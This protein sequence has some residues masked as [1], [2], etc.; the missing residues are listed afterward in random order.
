[1]KN[2]GKSITRSAAF[3]CLFAL[4]VC[5]LGSCSK[6]NKF[7]ADGGVYLDKKT[8]VSYEAAPACYEPMAVGEKIYGSS[9]NVTFYEIEGQDPLLWICESGGTVL[10]ADTIELPALDEMDISYIN[11]CVETSTTV[12]RGKVQSSEDIND[13]I[14][15]YLSAES[16]YYRGEAPELSYKIRFADSSL[17]I[18]YSVVFIRYAEDYTLKAEGGEV[19]SYGRDFLYNRFEDRFVKAPEALVKYIDELSL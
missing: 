17:G 11:I 19:Q 16:I 10:H 5:S 13:I 15:G 2:I 8:D 1:M 3:L 9:E 6:G 4:I 7:E 12:N 18:F 14:G